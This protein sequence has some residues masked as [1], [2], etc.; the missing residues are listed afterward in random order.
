[1]TGNLTQ[2]QQS[3]V[4]AWF[5]ALQPADRA[6]DSD[7]TP[8]GA[9]KMRGPF[10][11]DR[12]H[13][14]RLRRNEALADMA[15]ESAVW[16]LE[17]LLQLGDAHNEALF[18]IAGALAHVREDAQDKKSLAY[19]LGVGPVGKD[20]KPRLSELRFQ[21]LMRADNTEDFFQ[22]I[23]RTLNIG[24]KR[25]DVAVLANDLLAWS[26]EQRYA[27]R[28]SS[29]MKFRWA[30]DYYLKRP[31]QALIPDPLPAS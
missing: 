18:L 21:R 22:Q 16:R 29:G 17:E 28:R 10:S 6:S 3:I 31:D 23:R 11:F 25:A 24:D 13:R 2:Y 30:R 20:E 5:E 8:S 26:L 1:M 14:A 9:E 12:G 7:M 15:H 4:R 19:L 27:D